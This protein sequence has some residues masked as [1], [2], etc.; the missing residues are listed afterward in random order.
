MTPVQIAQ[1]RADRLPTTELLD[2]DALPPGFVVDSSYEERRL[3]EVRR[4][5]LLDNEPEERLS[6]VVRL[7]AM[8]LGLDSV[9]INLVDRDRVFSAASIGAPVREIPRDG[10]FCSLAI[11]Q[12]NLMVVPDASA[13]ARYRDFPFVQHGIRFYAGQPL[14]GPGGYPVGAL[15]VWGRDP[16]DL[17]PRE[18]ETLRDLGD[19]VSRELAEEAEVIRASEVQAALVP[20]AVPDL[21]GYEVAGQCLPS[22]NLSG[23]FYDWHP[24]RDTLQ[25]TIAD[26]M[27][28]GVGAAI[29]AAGLRALLRGA[30]RHN[31]LDEAV[32]RAA[33]SMDGDFTATGAFATLWTARLDPRTHVLQYVDAGH[34]LAIILSPDGSI[35]RLASSGMPIGAL[36]GDRWT[37][38]EDHL[39]PGEM[40]VS[41]SDGTLDL[42]PDLRSVGTA[43]RQIAAHSRSAEELVQ[44]MVDLARQGAAS[45][46]VTFLAL[47]RTGP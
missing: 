15:C 30:S 12:P 17:S 9:S 20:T 40:L 16:R 3:T 41:T 47:W 8:V 7:A 44:S 46:D 35:R 27:G 38:H 5:G 4:L 2:E 28:K 33:S 1:T 18:Q 11:Q 25:I 29:I 10:S 22:R 43:L 14:V 19:L 39:A 45:D 37:M 23:D 24:I 32:A 26:V 34:G 13:D 6:R 31:E 21:P 36:Q 42:F